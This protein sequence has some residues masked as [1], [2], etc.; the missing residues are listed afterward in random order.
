MTAPV[1]PPANW[2]RLAGGS[3]VGVG[4]SGVAGTAVGGTAVGATTPVTTTGVG[5]TD[6]LVGTTITTTPP[7]VAVGTAG[8]GVVTGGGLLLDGNLQAVAMSASITSSTQVKMIFLF[9]VASL[10]PNANIPIMIFY[11][12]L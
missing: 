10:T 5:G 7:V 3:G 2:M 8:S 12:I 9:M 6:V 4:G 1:P 11:I